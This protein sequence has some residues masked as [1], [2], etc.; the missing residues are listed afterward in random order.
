MVSIVDYGMGN[1][2]SV[3]NAVEMVGTEAE[4]CRKP[5]ELKGAERII[6]PGVG[7]FRDCMASLRKGGFVE[8][9]EEA[10]FKEGKPILGICLGMQAMTR[11]SFEGGEFD[12]LGWFEADVVRLTPI[13]ST[14]LNLSSQEPSIFLRKLR[15]PKS[16]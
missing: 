2:L 14:E 15:L 10:V 7:A 1:L 6:L 4:I 8:A 11:R 12:G 13:G 3:S 16:F 9:L 5:E